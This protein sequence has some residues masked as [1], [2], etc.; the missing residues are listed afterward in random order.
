MLDIITSGFK[1]FLR[2][3]LIVVIVFLCMLILYLL[4]VAAILSII[5]P[6]KLI[7]LA[8]AYDEQPENVAKELLNILSEFSEDPQ[9]LFIFIV[10]GVAFLILFEFIIAGVIGIAMDINTHGSFKFPSFLNYGFLFTP[11]MLFLEFLIFGVMISVLLPFS[12]LYF[13]F[14]SYLF[15]IA[16]SMVSFFVGILILP[17][18]FVLVAENCGVFD[19]LVLGMRFALRNL[20]AILTI[21]IIL[22]T[23]VAPAMVIQ[24]FSIILVPIAFSLFAIWYM[25]LYLAKSAKQVKQTSGFENPSNQP[26]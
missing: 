13:F 6:E 24:A 10:L 2:N 14:E 16:Q 20:L 25:R 22:M 5:P 3:P 17:S 9:A 1:L 8:Y 12:T 18:R 4:F 19:A 26:F 23:L 11:R 21:L 15:Q 7:E